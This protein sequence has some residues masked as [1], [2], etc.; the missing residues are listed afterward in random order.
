LVEDPPL[1]QAVRCFL[2]ERPAEAIAR[3][4]RY[5]K[6][7]QDLL[8]A[9][10][11]LAVRLTEKDWQR[12]DAREISTLLDQLGRVT[13][14]LHHRAPLKIKEMHLC[15]WVAGFGKYRPLPENYG[16]KPGEM[17]NLYVEL[18]NL[19]DEWQGKN[20]SFHLLTNIEI[21]DFNSHSCWSFRFHDPGPSSSSSERH[22]FYH[23]CTF[24]FPINKPRIAPGLYTLY[25]KITDLA[26]GREAE[27]TLDFRVV[28]A[29]AQNGW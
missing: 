26:T 27:R 6:Q 21:R 28:S 2:D 16:F 29:S 13:A 23:L 25:V 11:P 12:K 14:P 17:V 8:L 7:S 5:D 3:L 24:H 9:F 4:E 20:Y 10:L 15:E 22:D 1:V 18:Q 19:V